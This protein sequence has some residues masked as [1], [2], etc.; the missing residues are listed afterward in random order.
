MEDK[1]ADVANDLAVPQKE[2][3]LYRLG[4]THRTM[5]TD[6]HVFHGSERGKFP[7]GTVVI[8][9]YSRDTYD[10]K[11]VITE[12]EIVV[13]RDKNGRIMCGYFPMDSE[14]DEPVIE[15]VPST[16][17]TPDMM[18][19][20]VFNRFFLDILD[21][22]ETARLLQKGCAYPVRPSRTGCRKVPGFSRVP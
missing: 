10:Q 17:V 5:T 11:T 2:H 14:K 6:N 19:Y 21:Y 13:Y 20:L 18:V 22:R 16:H 4:K 9:T 1:T 8:K 3:R 12:Y 7:D 15:S